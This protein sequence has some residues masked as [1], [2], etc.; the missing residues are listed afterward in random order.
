MASYLQKVIFSLY[1][2][3]QNE[4]KFPTDLLSLFLFD[5]FNDHCTET[6]LKMIDDK[7]INPVIIPANCTETLAIKSEC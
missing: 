3:K 5:N 6:R 1:P 4:L 7:N 2:K